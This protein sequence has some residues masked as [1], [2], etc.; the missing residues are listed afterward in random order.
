[1]RTVILAGTTTPNCVRTTCYDAI[2]LE[3]NAV[4]LT[5]CCS[6]QTEEIQRV[7]LEDMQRAG[8]ILMDTAAFAAY[9][10]DTVPDLSA[11]I[12]AEMAESD[13]FPEPFTTGMDSVSWT[14]KW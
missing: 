14:D 2:A 4:V 11:A 8:A 13:A 7:N 9:G 5:D 6:S 1:M 3:Y 12:R 10:P